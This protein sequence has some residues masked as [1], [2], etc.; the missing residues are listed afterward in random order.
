M[1]I[2]VLAVLSKDILTTRITH[3]VYTGGVMTV[4]DGSMLDILSARIL[5]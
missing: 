5:I 4:V 1:P 3:V 2:Y